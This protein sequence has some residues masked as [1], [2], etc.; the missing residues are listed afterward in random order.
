MK[1]SE[2]YDDTSKRWLSVRRISI[3]MRKHKNQIFLVVIVLYLIFHVFTANFDIFNK[4]QIE[5]QVSKENSGLNFKTIGEDLSKKNSISIEHSTL[6]ERMAYYFPYEPEKPIPRS[7]WQ[8]WKC[9]ED[10][11]DFPSGYTVPHQSWKLLNPKSDVFL[12]S[13]D[14]VDS[15]IS[16]TFADIPEIV[17]TF[18]M[19]PKNILRADFFR[20]LVIF[21][22]GGT[23]SDLDTVCLKPID[24]WAAFDP[25]YNDNGKNNKSEE[26]I[27]KSDDD[28]HSMFTSVGLIMGIEA[29]PDRPDWADWY[30]RRIQFCQWTIQGKTGHPL[31]RELIIRIVQETE[32]KQ[33][34]GKLKTVEGKDKGGD[35]MQWT[36]PAIF[37][38]TVLDYLN[39]VMS[40]G[41]SGDGYGIGSKYWLQN[42]KYK[43]TK[44][45]MG[46]NGEPLNSD[47][48]EINW[49]TFTNMQQPLIIDDVMVLPITSFSPG[50]GQMGSKSIKNPLAYVQHLFGGTWK[51]RD[52]RMP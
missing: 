20:Y 16:N 49:K 36:G 52:E 21:A 31:L 32:R 48:Q 5:L 9:S 33:N 14:H 37:T 41:Q 12:I 50:V 8:T 30:A 47:R 39:N 44:P 19:L 43:V 51:P 29:D 17:R 38:D 6:R 27:S 28:G 46:E 25:K 11:P 13:D 42:K 34:M 18:E 15:F 3:F 35:I 24:S 4:Q 7:V 40:N 45:E 1:Y 23:Y 10:D 26:K 22:R 2:I